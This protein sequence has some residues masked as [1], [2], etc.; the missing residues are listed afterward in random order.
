MGLSLLHLNGVGGKLLLLLAMFLGADPAI[1][2]TIKYEPVR[3]VT[4]N[5]VVYSLYTTSVPD[6]SLLITRRARV[7]SLSGVTTS[8]CVIP[9]TVYDSDLTSYTVEG[10]SQNFTGTNSIITSLTFISPVGIISYGEEQIGGGWSWRI[11]DASGEDLGVNF[12]LLSLPNL[13]SLYING[14]NVQGTADNWKFERTSSKYKSLTD[15]YFIYCCPELTSGMFVSPGNITVHL[16]K[17]Y[18]KE[19]LHNYAVWCDFKDIV[20]YYNSYTARVTNKSS[21]EVTVY[22][23][24]DQNYSEDALVE[25][26]SFRAGTSSYVIYLTGKNYYLKLFYDVATSNMPTLTRNGEQVTLTE[27]ETGVAGYQETDVQEDI[28]YVVTSNNKH[29]RLSFEGSGAVAGTYKITR[30]GQTYTGN[31]TNSNPGF[32]DCDY[33]TTATLTMPATPYLLKN[34]LK[35]I[36]YDSPITTQNITLPTPVNGQ[37][38]INLTIPSVSASRFQYAYDIPTEV[39]DEDPKITLIRMGE[40][41]VTFKKFWEWDEQDERWRNEETI[42]CIQTTTRTTIPY[43]SSLSPNGWGFTLTMTPLKGH[44]LRE[45]M[46]GYITEADNGEGRDF[47]DWETPNAIYN[48]TTNTYTFTVDLENS[49]ND[50]MFGMS[51]LDILVDIGPL[52]TIVEDGYKQTFVRQGGTG[53]VYLNYEE[54]TGDYTPDIEVGTTTITI[55]DY[56]SDLDC[57]YA[58]LY[59]DYVK[60]EKFTAYRNGNDVTDQFL[61]NSSGSK[62]HFDFDGSEEER[63]ASVWTLLFEKDE[64]VVTGYDWKVVSQVLPEGSKLTIVYEDEEDEHV[65]T[66]GVNDI[67]INASGLQSVRF[68]IPSTQ[69]FSTLLSR[70]GEDMSSAMTLTDGVYS[71]TIPD[72]QIIDGTWVVGMQAN[73][74]SMWTVLQMMGI[75]GAEVIVN[76][77]GEDVTTQLTT[78]STNIDVNNAESVTLRV[79][80]EV[81]STTWD[82]YLNEIG[83]TKL[84]VVKAVKAIT[85]WGLAESKALVDGVEESLQ[86]AKVKAFA[87]QAEAEEAKAS[88]VEAGATATVKA[89]STAS[90]ITKVYRDGV[91]YTSNMT[92]DGDYMTCTISA[93]DLQTTTWLIMTVDNTAK[94]DVNEDGKITI[95]DVTKLVNIILGKE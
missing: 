68:E 92:A 63:K 6:H 56:S 30:D 3:D 57:T 81:S 78:A 5:G 34:S 61:L 93:D 26:E 15:I 39:V 28:S 23:L 37:Y 69:G 79:P 87:T 74:S 32:V 64:N 27:L 82:L 53:Q 25:E 62:Y 38:T 80:G 54:N 91:D 75:E 70:D 88:L 71:L 89:P 7:K 36:I 95:A 48:E 77:G 43:P 11:Q 2:A 20:P 59:I 55:P 94:G 50:M 58:D 49:I 86:P 16:Y 67:H 14:L 4:I 46:I 41:E 24:G 40:G 12:D 10:I 47:I 22:S 60:G 8:K 29:C 85:G 33:G 72:L 35:Q 9:Y 21:H 44:V 31:I 65:L 90:T 42:N 18:Y 51:D 1:A 73:A 66:A 84:E 19:S 52:E 83:A 13:K 76:R 45:F 17:L